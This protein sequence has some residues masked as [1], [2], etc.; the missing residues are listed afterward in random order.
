MG[1]LRLLRRR[2]VATGLFCITAIAPTPKALGQPASS[3]HKRILILHFARPDE[4]AFAG[5]EAAIRNTLADEFGEGLE[6]SSEYLDLIRFAEPRFQSAMRAYLKARYADVRFDAIVA[7]SPAVLQFLESDPS[8]FPHV[9]V[10]FMSRPGVAGPPGAT[11][12]V[13]A[14]SFKESLATALRLHPDATDV[15]VV[16]GTSDFDRLY[17]TTFRNEVASLPGRQT[18]TYLSGLTMP[19]LEERVRRLP[20][21]TI[22]YYISVSADG[23]GDRFMPAEVVERLSVAANAPVY[24]WHEAMLGHGI[25]G[26]RLHSSIK[27]AEEAARLAARVLNGEEPSAIPIEQ[28]DSDV[29]EFDWRQLA[30]W[31][32]P[33]SVLP[34]GSVVLFRRYSF[35]EQYRSYVVAGLVV[36][37]AQLALIVGLVLQRASRRRVEAR[38]RT[39]EA[40]LQRANERNT[41]I[42]RAVP[43]LMFVI[44]RDG[45]YVDY[46]ARDEKL[47]WAPP[48]AFLGRTVREIMPPALAETVMDAIERAFRR[49]DPVVLEYE[50]PMDET[51]YFEA[52]IVP[53]GADR[54][55][56]IVRD[57]TE[58]KRAAQLN[59]DLAGRLIASQEAERRRIARELHDDLSQK[60]ALLMMDIEWLAN[61]CPQERGRF[62]ELSERAHEIAAGLHNLSYELHPSKLEALGLL[63]ALK[64][65]CRDMS[66]QGGVPIAFTHEGIF[67]GVDPNVSL[68]LYRITQE[69]LHNVARHSHAP[70]AHVRLAADAQHLTLHIADSGVGFDSTT[71]SAGLGLV[72]MRERAALLRGE[73][74]VDTFPGGG[75]RIGVRVPLKGNDQAQ[76]FGSSH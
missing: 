57:L 76:G 42:L 11:G 12:I 53:T 24:S 55:L 2:T 46:N 50:L 34:A 68:C 17:E 60:T 47:L 52:R 32:I 63:S 5:I 44:L 64:A 69:A 28:L 48:S 51:R 74:V 38:L 26:G 33:T 30:R 3:S 40:A 4:G 13:S 16:S 62:L 75:T 7:A 66:L 61:R 58:A 25:V 43:D 22:I 6:Y 36:F 23:T 19:Q 37:A 8:L 72:S 29:Y 21:H 59:R 1:A 49:D 14:V 15:F 39:N 56:T 54:V 9:P 27:D 41:A 67:G 65:L 35:W 45:T 73:V 70:D 20:P 10:V 71:S 31:R 18:V